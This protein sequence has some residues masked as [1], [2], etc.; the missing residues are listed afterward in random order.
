M[1]LVL[2]PEKYATRFSEAGDA[3]GSRSF[4]LLFSN[5]HVSLIK[6]VMWHEAFNFQKFERILS[7]LPEQ[8]NSTNRHPVGMIWPDRA[9]SQQ[10]RFD[11]STSVRDTSWTYRVSVVVGYREKICAC[12]ALL[13]LQN[14]ILQGKMWFF[15][16]LR[17]AIPCKLPFYET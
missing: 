1:G 17:R 4:H 3:N 15:S 8:W 6:Y 7:A 16:R 5:Y 2:A 14:T 11:P 12:G 10:P 9:V 13:Y